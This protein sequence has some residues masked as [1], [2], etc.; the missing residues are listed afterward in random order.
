MKLMTGNHTIQLGDIIVKILSNSEALTVAE[1]TF[2][3]DMLAKEHLHPH[4][5]V[6]YVVK[7]SFD[8]IHDGHI[9]HLS[10]GEAICIAP[11]TL[12]NIKS[13]GAGGVI[14][15]SWTPSRGD[16]IEKLK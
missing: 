16:L 3:A 1:L 9:T 4:E 2:P 14:L 8:F 11:G 5:E 10:A 13:H 7:G 15:T 6:N 12:H